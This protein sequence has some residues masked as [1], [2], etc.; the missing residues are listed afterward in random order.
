MDSLWSSEE[1]ASH[2]GALGLRVYTSRLLGQE[3]SL[4]LHGGGNTSVKDQTRNIFGEQV[5]TLYVKGSG[6]DLKTLEPAGL[7]PTCL[8]TLCRLAQL[9][10]LTDTEMAR[11]LKAALLDPSAPAP[12][13]EA[14]LHAI[15]PF[16]YVDHTHADAVVAISNTPDGESLLRQLYADDILI[17]PYIMPGFILSKQVFE[18]TRDIDWTRIRGIVLLHHGV[19]TFADDA[20][21]SYENMIEIVDLA[22][23][24]LAG[25]GAAAM[26]AEGA[27]AFEA[28][29]AIDLAAVRGKVS[30][31]AGRPMLATLRM[32]SDYVGYSSRDDIATIACGGPI[33][34]D[35]TLHTK[36]IPVVLG[37]ARE[38][39]LEAALEDYADAYRSYFARHDS[40][41]LTCLDAAPRYAVWQQRGV[42]AFGQN[43]GRVGVVS[44]IARHTLKAVQ[45]AQCLGGWQ[46]L[47]EADIFQLEYWELEQAKLKRLAAPGA[48]EGRVAVVTGAASGIGLA[49]LRRLQAE[50]ACVIA[51]DIDDRIA[52]LTTPGVLGMRCD[53]TDAEAVADALVHGVCAF[54]G[55]DILVSN[56]GVFS[57]SAAIAN[58]TDAAL[59]QSLE[60]NF[61]SHVRLLRECTPYLR[62]GCNPSVVLIASK[63]VPA[64]G[65]GAA[66][67]STAKAALTQLGRVAA[68]ELGADGVRVNMLHPNAVYDT[69]IWTDQVLA[70]RA[71]NYGLTVDQYKSNNVLQRPVYAAD[72]AGAVVA[73]AGDLLPATTGA[74]IAVDGGNERVI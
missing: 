38:S 8:E 17:L 24:F 53:V 60:L 49:C 63:N 43:I 10:T 36:R 68:L 39:D 30:E 48:F 2:E 74:Q 44:D 9:P 21:T 69:G 67:Y 20:R 31:L 3:S 35:H 23:E 71:S 19:F 64:P 73:L 70:E 37:C 7:S 12:S 51:L 28:A 13:V 29:D 16:K 58:L 45:W 56:A 26:R 14:I 25:Q 54:G 1:A 34:P 55:I 22:E 11:E 41:Q 46:A 4:V 18:A 5:P 72:V 15:I 40:G 47:P 61:S 6:W 57:P 42:I 62:R 59:E 32:E 65:P 33:T 50:G 27:S 52:D 66:A